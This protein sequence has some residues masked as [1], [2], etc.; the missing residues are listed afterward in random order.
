MTLVFRNRL[1]PDNGR[2]IFLPT[3]P[4]QPVSTVAELKAALLTPGTYRVAPGLYVGDFVA[5]T[6]NVHLVCDA[7]VIFRCTSSSTTVFSM[8]ASN[9]SITGTWQ[10]DCGTSSAVLI[11]LDTNTL[12]SQQPDNVL[13]DGGTVVP[14]YTNATGTANRGVACHGSN[15]TISHC[16][17][18]GFY[19]NG[20]EVQAISSWNTNGPLTVTD[21]FI[22][23]AGEN[24]LFGGSEIRIPNAIP[25]DVYFARC[26]FYKRPSWRPPNSATVKNIFE[27][28][29]GQRFLLED[30]VFDGSWKGSQTGNAL[31]LT[32]R[33]S[34]A[35]SGGPNQ[36]WVIV[37]DITFRHNIIRNNYE[38]GG[39]AVQIL[40]HDDQGV[41]A[42]PAT[43]R[44][45]SQQTMILTFQDNLFEDSVGG[46]TVTYGVT[47]N[48]IIDHNTFAGH[49]QSSLINWAGEI[50]A[51]NPPSVVTMT[52]N[53]AQE[54]QYGMTISG[55][56]QSPIG[57]LT[58]TCS[59]WTVTNNVFGR[60]HPTGNPSWSTVGTGNV[61][62]GPAGTGIVFTG[63]PSFQITGAQ[64]GA[65]AGWDGVTAGVGVNGDG[66]TP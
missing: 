3:P 62:V 9:F 49:I 7:G 65:D 16:N 59:S 63:P 35:S 32:V 29:N 26:T 22:E 55:G 60:N 5:T 11:G 42:N 10:C 51:L 20:Q 54:G 66:T 33:N 64:A 36:P 58:A 53:A 46:L 21:C 57:A 38:P 40:G 43:G 45:D 2:Q 24:V 8:Q 28:K 31:T 23:G 6:A 13:L 17:V 39:Y 61:V 48:L 15:V 41:G 12:Q 30:N 4:Q 27:V 14:F 56:T 52:N 37:N 44:R 47:D 50:D 25:S 18:S 34:G 19:R 1:D